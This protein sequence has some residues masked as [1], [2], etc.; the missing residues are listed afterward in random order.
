MS[1]DILCSSCVEGIFCPTWAEWK[2]RKFKKRI[3]SKPTT[4]KGYK[5]RPKDFKDPKCQC[6]DCL[7]NEILTDEMYEEI[8]KETEEKM[9]RD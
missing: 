3:Y 2:C 5:S 9:K 4:C 7:K 8:D 1:K 6:E